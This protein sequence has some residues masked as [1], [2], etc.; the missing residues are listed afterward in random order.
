[1]LVS[2]SISMTQW[3]ALT[4]FQ[5]WAWV[6][7]HG[8]ADPAGMIRTPQKELAEQWVASQKTVRQV[9]HDLEDHGLLVRHK[10][11]V[12][13]LVTPPDTAKEKSAVPSNQTPAPRSSRTGGS[14]TGSKDPAGQAASRLVHQHAARYTERF[15]QPFPVAWAR[16]TQIYKRL[17]KVYGESDVEEW[18]AQYLAQALDS[19]SGRCGFCIL[20]RSLPWKSAALRKKPVSDRN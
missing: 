5:A 15:D 8:C 6:A 16:D 20:F 19:W 11:S 14:K 10:A 4:P 1:M 7:L 17:V 13:Q 9:L 18:Q 12:W 3:S 2:V